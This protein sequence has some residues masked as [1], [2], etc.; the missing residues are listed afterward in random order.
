MVGLLEFPVEGCKG[1][2][3]VRTGIWVNF[4]RHHLRETVVM[5]EEG[6]FPHPRYPRCDMLV[7]WA[8]P[9]GR[10]INTTL[11]YKGMERKR[12]RMDAEEARA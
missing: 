3:A 4:V 8:A 9:K 12:H 1:R 6:N 2:V 11:C 10:H 5:V 7:P